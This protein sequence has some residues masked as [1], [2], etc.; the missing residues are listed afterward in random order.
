MWISN[1]GIRGDQFMLR[2]SLLLALLTFTAAAQ[3]RQTP[4]PE[5]PVR[6]GGFLIHQT[7]IYGQYYSNGLSDSASGGAGPGLRLASDLVVGG[8]AAVGYLRTQDRLQLSLSYR[9]AYTARV[10]YS[11]LNGLN[12]FFDFRVD[13]HLTPATR[14]GFTAN[15]SVSS[16]EEFAFTPTEL[17][18]ITSVNG[19]AEDLARAARG[20]QL[21]DSYLAARLSGVRDADSAVR[22]LLFGNRVLNSSLQ[23][24]FAHS[25]SPRMTFTGG[26]GAVRRQHLGGGE[27]TDGRPRYLI[28]QMTSGNAS[29]G[30]SYAASPR[31]QFGVSV[32]SIRGQ[33]QL[34]NS[35][36]TLSRF[37]VQRMMGPRW[38]VSGNGGF[39]T[40]IAAQ[41]IPSANTGPGYVAG[42]SL[43]IDRM[44]I[45]S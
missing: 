41:Q 35:Y 25:L 23:A 18:L 5:T 34:Q 15:S 38:F 3:T 8:T 11:E 6:R 22:L 20:L 32:E 9:S 4:A 19:D 31:T 39:A 17:S 44:R 33:S 21:G 10:R 13:Q 30:L 1:C 14:I 27:A 2:S 29:V 37:S 26:V 45:P 12:H 16:T 24:T 42:G 36:A 43:G 28:P 7:A 40:V